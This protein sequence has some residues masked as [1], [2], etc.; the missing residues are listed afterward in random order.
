MDE[1]V[2]AIF[3]LYFAAGSTAIRTATPGGMWLSRA[4]QLATGTYIVLTPISAPEDFVMNSTAG[5]IDAMVQW[6]VGNINAGSD[7]LVVTGG[8]AVRTLYHDTILTGM[9]GI[10]CLMAKCNNGRGPMLDPDSDGYQYILEGRY[11]LG[12]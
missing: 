9:T 3:A 5:T 4:P 8:A 6:S 2:K 12:R 10:N 11:L 7:T 1:L